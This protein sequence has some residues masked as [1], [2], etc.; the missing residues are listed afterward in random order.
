MIIFIFI[1]SA[2][3][4]QPFFLYYSCYSLILFRDFFFTNK[5][6]I[7]VYCRCLSLAL[8]CHVVPIL[9]AFKDT[10]LEE[11]YF[12]SFS[13]CMFK[14]CGNKFKVFTF[15]HIG[16]IHSS[17]W[18]CTKSLVTCHVQWNSW[19]IQV[20]CDTSIVFVKLFIWTLSALLINVF[21]CRH[22][23][24]CLLCVWLIVLMYSHLIVWISNCNA[25]LTQYTILDK[26]IH[27]NILKDF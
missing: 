23:C 12:S 13:C 24:I 14:Q 15:S 3:S 6:Q 11:V 16:W 2:K 17:N 20:L 8:N 27:Y 9:K 4:P 25:I 19:I 1:C 5:K 10:T 7:C 18:R 22:A 26:C 21:Y